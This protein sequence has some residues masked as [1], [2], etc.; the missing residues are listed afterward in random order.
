M[1]GAAFGQGGATAVH[2]VVVWTEEEDVRRI[3]ADSMEATGE[4]EE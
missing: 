2:F 3:F 4:E 1:K